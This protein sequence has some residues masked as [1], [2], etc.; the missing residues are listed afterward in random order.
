MSMARLWHDQGKRDED[1]EPQEWLRNAAAA[2]AINSP[3]L[4]QRAAEPVDRRP[5]IVERFATPLNALSL[6]SANP[7]DLKRLALSP[8]KGLRDYFM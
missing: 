4:G 6:E 8:S 7:F 1:R 5:V 3:R 2:T